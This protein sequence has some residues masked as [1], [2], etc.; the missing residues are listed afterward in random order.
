MPGFEE[1]AMSWFVFA[2]IMHIVLSII[3]L[4]TWCEDAA[5]DVYP[6]T[7]RSWQLVAVLLE[8]FN[9]CMML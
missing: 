3:H 6:A 1:G 7:Y 5:I 4:S 2:A 8:T 9:L